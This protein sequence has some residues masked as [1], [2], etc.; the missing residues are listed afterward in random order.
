MVLAQFEINENTFPAAR[1][2]TFANLLNVIIPLLIVG[3]AVLLLV[4]LLYGAFKW[5]T[6]GGTS[7]NIAKAQ[8]IISFAILGLVVV[9]MSFILV[10]VISII[11]NISAPL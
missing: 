11:F 8:K 1:I 5:L 6:A 9:I 4:M 2:A 10:K 3:A 7:E